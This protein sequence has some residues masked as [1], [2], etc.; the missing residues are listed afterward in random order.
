[1]SFGILNVEISAV[2][3]KHGNDLKRNFSRVFASTCFNHFI[4]FHDL[5]KKKT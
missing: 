1:M 3:D 5:M 2:I 4:N